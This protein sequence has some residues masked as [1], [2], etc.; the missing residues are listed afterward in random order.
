MKLWLVRHAQPLIEA[1]VC[2]G[3]LDMAAD[4]QATRLCAQ[5]LAQ[6]LPA[7]VALVTSPLQR[8]EQLA[9]VLLELR[10]DLTCKKDPRLQ[11]MDFGDWEGRRWD[12]IGQ[13]ALEAWVADFARHRPGGGESVQTFMQRVAAA[14][15]EL[16]A[17]TPVP[18]TDTVWITHAGVMRAATLLQSG[19]RQISQTEQWP[20]ATPGFGEWRVLA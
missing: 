6:T 11:E 3:R 1:G 14:W 8:C 10:P 12:A 7:G 9:E 19:L 4:A 13:S 20:T 17:E 15:D 16:W 18:L 2:Y 5:A